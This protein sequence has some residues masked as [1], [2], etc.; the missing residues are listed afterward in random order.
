[1]LVVPRAA[2]EKAGSFQG[3]RKGGEHYLEAFMKPGVASFM[4]RE[5]AEE[6]PSH[7]QIIAYAIFCHRGRI[8]HYTRGGSGGEARLHDKGSIGI[9]GH[10]NPV[11]RQ[12]GHDDVATYMAGVERE[13]REELIIDG[14]C[15]QRVLGVINDDSNDVGS[16]HLGIVHL[17]ELDTDQVRANED[18]LDNLR[19]VEPGELSGELFERLETWSQLA[20]ELFNNSRS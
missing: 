15:T 14:G 6:D 18:A 13:I 19:F 1:M 3:H 5:K 9:G 16:V 17:F 10:I 2:F 8:L 7:K 20:L 12:S 11:D 4:D